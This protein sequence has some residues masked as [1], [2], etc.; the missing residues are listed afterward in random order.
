MLYIFSLSEIS[1]IRD[2][3]R[4]VFKTHIYILRRKRFLLLLTTKYLP[5][6]KLPTWVV[7][8]LGLL[9]HANTTPPYPLVAFSTCNYD[10]EPFG[11]EPG[12]CLG[13]LKDNGN[14]GHYP[15]LKI[16]DCVPLRRTTSFQACV[17][18]RCPSGKIEV[19]TLYERYN[20]ME[21]ALQQRGIGGP[22]VPC[23]DLNQ[24]HAVQS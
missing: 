21:K 19:L 24:L 16:G 3:F 15:D 4:G 6:F 2:D 7:L 1:L 13:D 10:C 11:S 5:L 22:N 20:C 9:T 17:K 14:L 23:R 8:S 12:P 18:E